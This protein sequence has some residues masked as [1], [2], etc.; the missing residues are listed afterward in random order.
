MEEQV[1]QL[2]VN[3]DHVAT[4]R[5]ARGG[6]E[7]DPLAAALLA[8]QS[9][10]DSIVCHL[11]EDR[12]H[13]RDEDVRRI[14]AAAKTS[15]QLELALYEDVIAVAL[16]V[17][18]PEV[19]VVPERR[20][21]VTT[22]GGFDCI[23]HADRLAAAI[24][25]FGAAGIGVSVFIDAEAAQVEAAHRLG[26]RIIELHT[27]PYCHATGDAELAR[28]EAAAKRGQELGLEVH[29]GHGL[30]YSNISALVRQVPVSKVNIGHS[31]VS[32]A[33]FV[34]FGKAVSEM[35]ALLTRV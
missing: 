4:V 23:Q 10:A 33:M 11:R 15:L 3:I 30:N 27:G 31:I 34:G 28:L 35:K 21:E 14:A 17:K 12:R 18:P 1:V 26:A 9:G 8:E 13:I 20:E 5:N 22:E 6:T 32:R 16:E 25:R 29:A 7:P 2:G 24:A 19:M